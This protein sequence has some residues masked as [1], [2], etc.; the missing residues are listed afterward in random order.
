MR[1]R[2]WR[3]RAA[4]VNARDWHLMR[5][6]PYLARLARFEDRPFT[7]LNTAFL[8]DGALVIV[9]KGV[10]VDPPIHLLHVSMTSDEP[11]MSGRSVA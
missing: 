5:G 8:R 3:A 11:T 2:D 10:R 6:D 1:A 4:S 9:G 7:A